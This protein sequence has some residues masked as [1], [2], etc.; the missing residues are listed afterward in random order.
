GSTSRG[1]ERAAAA[2][3]SSYSSAGISFQVLPN[4]LSQASIFFHAASR[5]PGLGEPTIAWSW[6]RRRR[7]LA[8]MAGFH[9]I[10]IFAR[11]F[12]ALPP[13]TI[14]KRPADHFLVRMLLARPERRDI[15]R[16][17]PE[18]YQVIFRRE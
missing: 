5:S 14:G 15:F 18:P 6:R 10:G 16:P 11:P 9:H 3:L 2:V 1:S 17:C 8:F 12:G 13:T 7:S 4:F